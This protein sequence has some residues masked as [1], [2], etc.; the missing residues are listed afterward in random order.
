[1]TTALPLLLAGAALAQ[2]VGH[3]HPDDVAARSKVFVG[4]AEKMGP[5]FEGAQQEL[6]ALGRGLQELEIGAA[7]LGARVP[8]GFADWSTAQRRTVTGQFLQVQRHVDL[9]Q[10]DFGGVFGTALSRA[11]DAEGGALKE[12]TKGTGV[13]ALMRRPGAGCPGED[14]NGALA[15]ALD[16]DTSLQGDVTEILDIPFPALGVD[17][18]AWAP[19]PLTGAARWVSAAGLANR[20]AGAALEREAAALEVQLAPLE[21]RI[22]AGD[23]TAVAEAAKARDGYEAALATAGTS[24][25]DAATKALD[26]AGA[27][28]VGVCPNAAAFGGCAGEDA[29]KA[30]L[31]TLAAD[32][33]FTKVAAGL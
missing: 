24:L 19:V 26:K 32:K 10:E 14:R 18:R 20:F 15:R 16:A 6:G 25:L 13:Q 21:A 11:L 12:C 8:G 17:E 2:P 27:G 29:S 5:A 9:V 22:A 3:F 4:A 30:L 33:R 7:V 28:D 23:A 31:Q 1:M